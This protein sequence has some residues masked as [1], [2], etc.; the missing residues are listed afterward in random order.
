M[1]NIFLFSV[2]IIAIL[3]SVSCKKKKTNATNT[4]TTT[5]SSTAES[6]DV[7]IKIKNVID[8]KSINFGVLEFANKAGNTYSV[9]TLQYYISDIEFTKTD[10]STYKTTTSTLIDASNSAMQ[11]ITLKNVPNAAFKSIKLNI[12]VNKIK[13]H[14]GLQE[15]DLD[16]MFGMFWSWNT[17]YIFFK[18]DGQFIDSLGATKG[19]SYHFGSDDA[20]TTFNIPVNF[21]INRI[22]K[23]IYL[24]FDLN[25]LYSS[26]NKID[27]DLGNNHQ[28]T[29]QNDSAWISQ[30]KQNFGNSFSFDYAE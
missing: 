18:H 19:L 8:S 2:F 24:N 30:L 26:P 17:G 7:T 23:K 14:T 4:T 11:T 21:T 9:S 5:N 22:A 12:G 13:N 3:V 27:F 20:Y 16:P 15:G 29:S 1:K 10:N 6:A 25:K 28:S